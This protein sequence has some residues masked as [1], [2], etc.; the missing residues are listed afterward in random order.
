MREK[1]TLLLQGVYFANHTVDIF[2]EV[3]RDYAISTTNHALV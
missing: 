2:S 1:L 3:S